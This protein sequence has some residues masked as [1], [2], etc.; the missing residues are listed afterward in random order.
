MLLSR[1]VTGEDIFVT[2]GYYEGRHVPL[3]HKLVRGDAAL[4]CDV[5]GGH[6]EFSYSRASIRGHTSL[7]REVIRT[8]GRH[9]SCMRSSVRGGGGPA[10]RW[11][12]MSGPGRLR[13]PWS[14]GIGGHEA[15]AT[16][17]T[18]ATPAPSAVP[19]LPLS[20]AQRGTARRTEVGGA[21]PLA[22]RLPTTFCL[23]VSTL[24]PGAEKS[25]K[26]ER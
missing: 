11:W 5:I 6:T 2:G 7:S 20:G 8:G 16:E 13:G 12:V 4:S 22:L 25:R 23:L 10:P 1:E 14:R 26:K 3:S 15:A 24:N 9:H 18:E 19:G 17:A 21:S